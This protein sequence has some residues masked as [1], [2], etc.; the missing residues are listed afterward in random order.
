MTSEI[1]H[2]TSNGAI[3][4]V[5]IILVDLN[6][7]ILKFNI[8]LKHAISELTACSRVV[9]PALFKVKILLFKVELDL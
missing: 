8:S 1:W 5:D 4:D 7:T 6:Q 2:G 9:D 3:L